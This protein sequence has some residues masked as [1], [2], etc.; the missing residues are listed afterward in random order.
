M[1]DINKVKLIWEGKRKPD[2]GE[3]LKADLVDLEYV[4][5]HGI[6]DLNY[7][8]DRLNILIQ[9][10]N[11][12]VVQK[13]L[14]KGY[15]GKLDFIYIDPPY[16][17]ESNYY[18]RVEMRDQGKKFFLSRQV[19]KDM[20]GQNINN[21]LQHMYTALV[22]MR[23]LLSDQ[24]S[25]FVHLDWH[26]HH[27]IRVIMDEVFG[28][29]NFVNEIIWCYGGGSG[30]KR[31]FHRKH[32]TILWYAKGRDYIFNP[33]YRAYTDKT[34]QRGLTR[35]KGDKYR[36]NEKGAMMQDW[37][38]DI[39]K[40]LSPTARENLKFPTQ[41][42]VELIKR[43]VKAA[44]LPDSL[45]GDFYAGAGSTLHACEDLGR[46]WIGCDASSIAV[47]T[48]MYRMIKGRFAPF[49]V[50]ELS[51]GR[52]DKKDNILLVKKPMIL[53]RNSDRL[54]VKVEIVDYLPSSDNRGKVPKGIS[55]STL[56]Y[57]WEIDPCYDGK[58]FTSCYQIYREKPIF[59]DNISLACDIEVPLAANRIAIRVYDIFGDSITV[60]KEIP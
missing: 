14:Q 42:P 28:P 50:Q 60:I 46:R 47:Q 24:G 2:R 18:S 32:D 21:Y 13:L 8:T 39:N 59:D 54:K 41:K 30:T 57:F 48:S 35:V 23:E 51:E 49:K 1:N 3:S 29:K 11:I 22:L 37:W 36:L 20:W 4:Y 58:L 5:P 7:G 38:T 34:L 52:E 43:L 15:H 12:K 17:S 33:Q 45:V 56:I 9:G 40:I 19:F 53:E 44:S 6:R 31:Y 16:W 25:I 26:A 27:Y 55:F 10:D